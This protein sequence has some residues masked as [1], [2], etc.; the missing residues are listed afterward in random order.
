V[1]SFAGRKERHRISTAQVGV[2]YHPR[3]SIFTCPDPLDKDKILR[4]I[5]GIDPAAVIT[6]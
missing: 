1:V 2:T 5:A 3:S 6:A 4:A